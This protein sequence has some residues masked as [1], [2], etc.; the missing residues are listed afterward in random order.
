MGPK[1]KP[2]KEPNYNTDPTNSVCALCG[3]VGHF[4]TTC[5]YRT[6]F[7]DINP[8]G[9]YRRRTTCFNCCQDGHSPIACPVGKAAIWRVALNK[10][11]TTC[12]GCAPVYHDLAT[13]VQVNR[14]R[15]TCRLSGSGSLDCCGA[16][17]AHFPPFPLD[18][19]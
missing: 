3:E 19:D 16:G 8:D 2:P 14:N 17:K 6:Q 5:P 4:M 10:A 1:K 15:K 12:Q 7:S 18:L 13:K 11:G 9:S